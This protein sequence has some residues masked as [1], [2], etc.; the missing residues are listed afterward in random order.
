MAYLAGWCRDA[1][2]GEGGRSL[3]DAVQE[4]Q[5]KVDPIFSR[6]IRGRGRVEKINFLMN[7][8]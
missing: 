1:D 3:A 2:Q 4:C 7:I 5:N 8:F 6:R